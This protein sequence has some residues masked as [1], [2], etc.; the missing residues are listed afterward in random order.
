MIE[1]G[2]KDDGANRKVSS[3]AEAAAFRWRFDELKG[4]Y[5][6]RHS[7]G[8]IELLVSLIADEARRHGHPVRALDIGCGKGIGLDGTA[9]ARVKQYV[10]QLW[11]LE[12]DPAITPPAGV[13]AHFQHALMETAEIEPNSID[14]AFS[15]LVMEHVQHPAEFLRAVHRVLKPG[16]A[17]IFLTVNGRHYFARIARLLRALHLDEAILRLIRPGE[18]DEY[19]YPIAYKCNTVRAIR[20]LAAEVGFEPPEFVFVERDE[21]SPYLRGPLRPVQV[22]LDK[23]RD[24]VQTPELLLEMTGRLR[25]PA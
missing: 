14:V 18:I 16:G 11:G 3:A 7:S 12:P 8:R 19:H 15:S 10:D 6:F 13:F 20:R 17:Y 4:S 23:K 5:N 21:P 22:V 9:H 1:S 24:V 2:G 25:K